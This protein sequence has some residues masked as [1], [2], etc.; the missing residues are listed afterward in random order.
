MS[1]PFNK[2]MQ[3]L[4]ENPNKGDFSI[5]YDKTNKSSFIQEVKQSTF[6]GFKKGFLLGKQEQSA[7]KTPKSKETMEVRKIEELKPKANYE[8]ENPL[9]FSEVQEALAKQMPLLQSK[10]R[11][12]F[13]L[14]DCCSFPICK[15]CVCN[16]VLCVCFSGV[17]RHPCW[18]GKKAWS[19]K[20]MV[21]FQE[22]KNNPVVPYNILT[23]FLAYIRNL[24]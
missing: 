22:K 21:W 11:I 12:F 17:A 20:I 23:T 5:Y 16:C 10:G 14:L 2:T 13:I 3:Y 19:K 9:V 24:P 7:S 18:R 15:L 6:G 8:K 1:I 4:K